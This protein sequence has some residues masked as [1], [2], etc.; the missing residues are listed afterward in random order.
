[1]AF[2]NIPGWIQIPQCIFSLLGQRENQK[3]VHCDQEEDLISYFNAIYYFISLPI[4]F[5]IWTYDGH[6]IFSHCIATLQLQYT[7]CFCQ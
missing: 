6:V 2:L 1:M 7:L 4:C 5:H 3:Y